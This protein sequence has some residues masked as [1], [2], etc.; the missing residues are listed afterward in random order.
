MNLSFDI[1]VSDSVI[2]EIKSLIITS[3]NNMGL[4]NVKRISFVKD[5]PKRVNEIRSEYGYETKD[6]RLVNGYGYYLKVNNEYILIYDNDVVLEGLT[7]SN[8]QRFKQALNLFIHEFLHVYDDIC[9]SGMKILSEQNKL[10][11]KEPLGIWAEYY[12]HRKSAEYCKVHDNKLYY[13]ILDEYAKNTPYTLHN[14][15]SIA[16]QIG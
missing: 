8:E 7:E 1:K 3:I 13:E 6:P 9:Q 12:A 10:F 2:T 15:E 16:R 11:Y 4:Y 5:F 14:I